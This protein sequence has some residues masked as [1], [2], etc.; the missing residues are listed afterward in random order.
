MT[1]SGLIKYFCF[2]AKITFLVTKII[3]SLWWHS[4]MLCITVH[5]HD[6]ILLF[7]LYFNVQYW[8]PMSFLQIQPFFRY[9]NVT[10]WIQ[11]LKFQSGYYLLGYLLG[12]EC[13]GLEKMWASGIHL[14]L[15]NTFYFC[16]WPERLLVF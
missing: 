4:F 6:Q 14:L 13:T 12:T 2:S 15:S 7:R 1:W 5:K 9:V 8:P 16:S 3:T 11:F 10:Y